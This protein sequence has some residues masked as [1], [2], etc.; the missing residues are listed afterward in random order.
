M[1]GTKSKFSTTFL[2]QTDGQTEIM[3]KNLGN[4]QRTLVGEHNES[5]NL[6]LFITEFA[7]NS[8]INRITCKNPHELLYGF[9]PRQTIDRIPMADHYSHK[10]S[11]SYG[12]SLQS[13]SLH[14]L[15]HHTYT[16]YIRRSVIRLHKTTPT[17]SY[18]LM[19]GKN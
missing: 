9:R 10:V 1:L 2:P 11:H 14:H 17:I 5:Q 19:L 18:E 13:Q 6:K 15:S 12:R 3:N 16:S 8:S 7:Y 4:L